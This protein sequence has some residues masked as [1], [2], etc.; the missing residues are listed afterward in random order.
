MTKYYTI[1]LLSLTLC[2]NLLAQEQLSVG[3]NP[4][5]IEF[6]YFPNRVYAVVWRNWNL[7]EA[8]R[9]AKTIGCRAKDVNAIAE[10]MGL[11]SAEKIP[12]DYKRR[13]YITILRRNWHLLPYDQLLTLLDMSPDKLKFSLRED[14]FLFQK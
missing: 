5:A 1:T 11:L 4:P 12:P 10:S 7:V 14:D 13:M 8:D 9:I 6:K 3:A 2:C